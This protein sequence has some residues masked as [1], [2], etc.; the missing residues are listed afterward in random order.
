MNGA[1][2]VVVAILFAPPGGQRRDGLDLA[3]VGF[4]RSDGVCLP[5]A[6]DQCPLPDVVIVH[7]PGYKGAP[8]L[9]GLPASW[10]P[11]PCIQQQST[12]KRSLIRIGVPL[13]LAWALTIHKAQ[14]ITEPNGVVVSF[15]GSRMIRAVSRMGLAFVAWTR[16]TAWE[17]MAFVALPPIEDFLAVRFSREFRAREVFEVWADQLHD[18]L[19]AARGIDEGEH[20]QKH[21]HHLR[22][23]L[24]QCHQREATEEE[25]ADVER[26]L[27]CRGVMPVS[28]SVVRAG[29]SKR[30]K[31]GGLWSIVTS[32]RADKRT[33][34]N[35]KR[36]L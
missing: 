14:G 13:K 24:G 23:F 18:A 11:V 19:L 36:S 9:P 10:V 21:Q 22:K 8:L 17:R 26:M 30:E 20:I 12:K 31:G 5:R 4:P 32:F 28:D 29:S 1:R 25:L 27:R 33:T 3:D 34:G 6:L 16:T 35:K 2:G 7:F 15:D